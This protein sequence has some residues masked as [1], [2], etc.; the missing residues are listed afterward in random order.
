V[1]V[2]QTDNNNTQFGGKPFTFFEKKKKAFFPTSETSLKYARRT[3]REGRNGA[4]A[5]LTAESTG[6]GRGK[7]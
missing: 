6:H 1:P 2:V 4:D 3:L 5:D 7:D